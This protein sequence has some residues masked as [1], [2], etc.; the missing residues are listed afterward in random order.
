MQQELTIIRKFNAPKSLVFGAFANA[1]ALAAW[2]GP[3]GMPI[4]VHNLDFKPG[5]IFHYKMEGNGQ[6]MWGVFNYRN[7]VEPDMIEFISSFSDEEGNIC[8]SPFPIDFPLEVF[9][10]V[11]L[12][13]ENGITTLTLKGHPV[14]ASSAQEETYH[15]MFKSMEQGFGGTMDQ[16]ESYLTS[17]Q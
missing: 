5:G 17:I 15:S 10:R 3:K 16:L 9:N 13:E 4:T 2:W 7:I 8:K 12:E 14:N 1:E 11:T 6:V